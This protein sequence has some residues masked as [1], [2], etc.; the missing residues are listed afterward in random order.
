MLR[1]ILDHIVMGY[2]HYKETFQLSFKDF[3]VW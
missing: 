3:E 2:P 1:E